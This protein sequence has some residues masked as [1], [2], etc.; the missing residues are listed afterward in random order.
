MYQ[1]LQVM[2]C[3]TIPSFSMPNA[4]PLYVRT[5]LY[6]S[7]HPLK[8]WTLGYFYLLAFV[9]DAIADTHVNISVPVLVFYSF[10][11]VP[12]RI[13]GL[14]KST[15]NFLKKLFYIIVLYRSCSIL[16]SHQQYV[17]FQFIH[18]GMIVLQVQN[19]N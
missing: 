17:A 6:L 11:C 7:F 12:R 5:T 9:N 19:M 10:G 2:A 14:C 1:C 3:V 13:A 4:I 16:C 8:G 15:L 18:T